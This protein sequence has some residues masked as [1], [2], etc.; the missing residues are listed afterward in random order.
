MFVFKTIETLRD[1]LD[2]H[3]GRE[4]HEEILKHRRSIGFTPTMG[5]LHEGHLSL[6]HRSKQ[7][8]DISVVS[9]FVN[10]TQF[11]NPDDLAKYPR[12][13]ERDLDMLDDAR[14][15]VVFTPSVE[16]M[17]PHGMQQGNDIDLNGLDLPMEGVFRPGH[18]KGMA[19][20]VKRLLDI[21][22]PHVIF[23]GQKDFQQFAIV[24]QMIRTLH[25][26]VDIV[27][28]PTIREADGLAMS[29]RNVRLAPEIRGLA[30]VIYQTLMYCAEQIDHIPISTLR[31]A[32][33]TK[34][35]IPGFRPEYF[36]IVD[37]D[38]LQPADKQTAYIVACCAVWA[39][40]VRLIDNMILRGL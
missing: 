24:R 23:M 15:D 26:P 12:T 29:S 30:S 1:Y 19:Q 22:Q 38:T 35:D 8:C 31:M 9:I 39:G 36:E 37:G 40:E 5:A 10:P 17:Y 21:V 14:C 18:F 27:M 13:I 25:M 32:C 2:H 33:M 28:C 3:E 4:G 34:L 16:E 20:V 11:N 7:N 6:L